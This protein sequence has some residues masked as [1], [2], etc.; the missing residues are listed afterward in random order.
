LLQSSSPP[1]SNSASVPAET[2][3][4]FSDL[5]N[6]ETIPPELTEEQMEKRKLEFNNG[7]SLLIESYVTSISDKCKANRDKHEKSAIYYERRFQWF[8]IMLI[9]VSFIVTGVTQ[10]PIGISSFFKYIILL[11]NLALNVLATINKFLRYQDLA[12][13][14]RLAKQKFLELHRNIT[15]QQLVEP[16]Y[17]QNGR[18]Y[19]QW[20]GRTFDSIIKG[21]PHPPKAVLN[22]LSV[23]V[24][25]DSE[26]NIP[27]ILQPI[28]AQMVPVQQQQQLEEGEMMQEIVVVPQEG[29]VV[30]DVVENQQ[31]ALEREAQRRRLER[32]RQRSKRNLP[33]FDDG[34]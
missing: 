18:F 32:Q 34:Y 17:R 15:E 29:V 19:I 23:V 4:D 6:I 26:I 7:W 2:Q 21:S 24:V 12:T 14:H 10:I 33:N 13:R 28:G 20:A 11:L 8:S 16:E 1:A 5:K 31:E 3:E 27:S 9:V 22:Q 25:P 30:D